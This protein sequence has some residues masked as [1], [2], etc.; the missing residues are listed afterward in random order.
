[1]PKKKEEVLETEEQKDEDVQEFQPTQKEL[2]EQGKELLFEN[3][4]TLNQVEEWKSRFNAIFCT[5]FEDTMFIWRTL[6]RL[7]YKE[8]LK[9]QNADALYREERI[10]EKC[11]L[12]PEEYSFV[13][14]SGGKAGIPSILAEQ[15]MEKSGFTSAEPQKL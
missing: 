1:M 9:V 13:Q 12:W 7:E 3:G 10:C 15:I 6:T 14:M 2:A 4:P 8:V 11:I 5:E